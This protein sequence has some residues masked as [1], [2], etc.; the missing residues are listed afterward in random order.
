MAKRTGVVRAMASL[1]SVKGLRT[2]K[3]CPASDNS[4]DI[5]HRIVMGLRIWRLPLAEGRLDGKESTAVVTCRKARLHGSDAFSHPCQRPGASDR[6]SQPSISEPTGVSLVW[7]AWFVRE[8]AIAASCP[9]IK[10]ACL[11]I[12]LLPYTP[13]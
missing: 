4:V 2:S 9:S 5:S 11:A 12:H 7:P 6:I 3:H 8:L 1:S 10:H 13:H